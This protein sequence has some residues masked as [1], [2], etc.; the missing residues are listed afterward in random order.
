MRWVL[1]NAEDAWETVKIGVHQILREMGVVTDT[2]VLTGS[3]GIMKKSWLVDLFADGSTSV[4][5]NMLV[6]VVTSAVNCDISSP[7]L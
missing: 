7:T 2:V 5:C 3:D 4:N 6:V 1:L